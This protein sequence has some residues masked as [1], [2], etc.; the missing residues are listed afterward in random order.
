MYIYIYIY[1]YI[2]IYIYT[3]EREARMVAAMLLETLAQPCLCLLANVRPSK[4]L[5]RESEG[6]RVALH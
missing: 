2:F 1:I 6:E 4:L 3:Y 5:N